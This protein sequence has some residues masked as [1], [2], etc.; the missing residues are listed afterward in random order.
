MS[1]SEPE[2]DPED[3]SG[4]EPDDAPEPPAEPIVE[5]STIENATVKIHA[6]PWQQPVDVLTDHLDIQILASSV[7]LNGIAFDNPNRA[8]TISDA[9]I[10]HDPRTDEVIILSQ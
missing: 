7:T 4:P 5:T 1:T 9:R 10:T 3:D 8:L 6:H 2:S